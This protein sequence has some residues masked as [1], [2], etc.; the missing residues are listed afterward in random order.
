[1]FNCRKLTYQSHDYKNLWAPEIGQ[2]LQCEMQSENPLDKYAV[3]VKLND[4]VV[5]HLP[6]GRSGRF[7]KT[8]FYFLRA[9]SENKCNARIIGKPFNRG[10]KKGVEVP[11]L[12][13]FCGKS[14]YLLRL[15]NVL[16]T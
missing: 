1:M 13:T 4:V 7:A 3:A 12:L 9:D 6:L 5:G 10:T 15:K 8:I 2:V 16:C 14:A 11:C